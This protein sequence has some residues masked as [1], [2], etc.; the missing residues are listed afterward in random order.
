[1]VIYSG[2]TNNLVSLEIVKKLG[3]K[4]IKN[5]TSYKVSW[6]KKG[7]QLLVSEQS[8]VEFR[9]GK[10][11][12]KIECDTMPM[13]FYTSSWVDHGNSTGRRCMMEKVTTTCLRRMESST[14]FYH[15]KKNI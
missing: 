10:Y 2:S 15:W 13:D 7:H 3:L 5:P 14:L 1:M 12:D 9:I 4:R 6:M 11:K 8:E